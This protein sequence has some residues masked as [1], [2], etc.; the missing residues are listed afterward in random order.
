MKNKSLNIFKI[1]LTSF[2]IVYTL[3]F[4]G[5]NLYDSYAHKIEGW[6]GF[7]IFVYADILGLIF[8]T[9]VFFWLFVLGCFTISHFYQ[10]IYKKSETKKKEKLPYIFELIFIIM[11]LLHMSIF[12][13][14]IK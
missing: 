14:W 10:R 5:I 11:M 8:E 3:C 13:R 4:L 12:L 9:A 1:T 2:P 7:F 6:E